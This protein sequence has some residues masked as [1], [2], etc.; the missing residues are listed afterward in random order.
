[1]PVLVTIALVYGAGRLLLIPIQLIA[2]VVRARTPTNHCSR[3][4]I[5]MSFNTTHI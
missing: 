2:V 3:C 5:R 1:M 4:T